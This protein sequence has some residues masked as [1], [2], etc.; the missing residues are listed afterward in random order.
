MK[1]SVEIQVNIGCGPRWNQDFKA[2]HTPSQ[3]E[4][5]RRGGRI[6]AQLKSCGIDDIIE[7]GPNSSIVVARGTSDER[8]VCARWR[9][10]VSDVLLSVR[11]IGRYAHVEEEQEFIAFRAL[12]TRNSGVR[13]AALLQRG[14][15][16][17]PSAFDPAKF[18]IPHAWLIIQPSDRLAL[19]EDM[20][21]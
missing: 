16:I 4:A 21:V 18:I 9:V 15:D 20:P 6:M 3:L 13:K 2:D 10:D 19:L 7:V 11:C 14:E 1:D 8:T 12:D 5:L 17:S